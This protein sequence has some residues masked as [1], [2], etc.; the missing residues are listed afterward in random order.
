MA[1]R[2]LA[3][4]LSLL[5]YFIFISNLEAHYSTLQPI[6]VQEWVGVPYADV[7]QIPGLDIDTAHYK[8]VSQGF[9]REVS[10]NSSINSIGSDGFSYCSGLLMT[11]AEAGIVTMAHL[12]PHSEV[13]VRYLDQTSRDRFRKIALFYGSLSVRQTYLESMI[14]DGQ[15]GTMQLKTTHFESNDRHWGMVFSRAANQVKVFVRH[16]S[17]TITTFQ[18]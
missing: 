2:F 13:I 18:S 16:P 4:Y 12:E 14:Q 11:D 1:H 6:H 5:W 3:K 17:Q 9:E 15:F 10:I 7:P 8:Y